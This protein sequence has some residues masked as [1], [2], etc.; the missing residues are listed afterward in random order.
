LADISADKN[1]PSVINNRPIL[2]AEKNRPINFVGRFLSADKNRPFFCPQQSCT[3]IGWR[4]VDDLFATLFAS[5]SI[6]DVE[7][8]EEADFTN[9]KLL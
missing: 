4:I 3:V 6:M 7:W 1:L 8:T 2:S 9:N 5:F